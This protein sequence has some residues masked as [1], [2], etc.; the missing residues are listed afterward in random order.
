M[1][2]V[3][4]CHRS[5]GEHDEETYCL[6]ER[7]FGGGTS[8]SFDYRAHS[9]EDERQIASFADIYNEWARATDRPTSEVISPILELQRHF[10]LSL[11]EIEARARGVKPKRKKPAIQMNL[12]E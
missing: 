12:F 9:A 1:L 10:G 8:P 5:L 6:S 11:A 7:L 3:L 2:L 4:A